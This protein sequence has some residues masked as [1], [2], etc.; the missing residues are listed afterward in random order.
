MPTYASVNSSSEKDD[1]SLDMYMPTATPI[2]FMDQAI[3]ATTLISPYDSDT[4]F[5]PE[6]GLTGYGFDG[7]WY[8]AGT[9]NLIH[10]K[11]SWALEAPSQFR[12]TTLAFP[13]LA[14]VLLSEASLTIVD[15]STTTF[16]LWMLFLLQDKGALTDNP[17]N[18]AVG[19]TP[20]EVEFA[21]GTLV[22]TYAPDPGSS[23]QGI[24]VITIDFKRDT[25]YRD[26]AVSP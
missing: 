3:R 14:L 11:A 18:D 12:G 5:H 1:F 17:L 22:V 9:K 26:M 4:F 21:N 23:N 2:N 8:N 10:S 20:R 15:A 24:M 6:L 25:V 19:F 16:P 13:T 7:F